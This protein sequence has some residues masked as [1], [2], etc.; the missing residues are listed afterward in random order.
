[1]Y[2]IVNVYMWQWYFLK[3]EPNEYLL[4]RVQLRALLLKMCTS[5]N[6]TTVNIISITVNK[7]TVTKSLIPRCF[8]IWIA[9]VPIP[10]EPPR[11]CK[12]EGTVIRNILWK[13]L[14]TR[15][16]LSTT[17]FASAVYFCMSFH[18]IMAMW[19]FW[20]IMSYQLCVLNYWL[21]PAAT[22]MRTKKRDI[23]LHYG[24]HPNKQSDHGGVRNV[25]R[26]V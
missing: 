2:I 5:W 23:C 9:K 22:I 12:I 25:L 7:P 16:I 11:I 21:L 13:I 14:L 3:K 15:K 26:E 18:I 8:A 6:H 4:K 24:T 17:T 1:M 20:W 10:L 19:P